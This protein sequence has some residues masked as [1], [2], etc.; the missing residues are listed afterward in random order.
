MFVYS[1]GIRPDIADALQTWRFASKLAIV[2]TCLAC[3][4]WATARLTRPEADQR[5]A[6]AVLALPVAML[7]LAGAWELAMSPP[8]AWP[9]L[10]I[11]R[12]WRLCLTFTVLMSVA[13]LV[14][15]LAALRAGAPR[16]PAVAGAASGLLAGSL[17][18][19]LYAA[20]CTDDS[21]LFVTLWY[22]PAIMLVMLAGAAAGYRVLRW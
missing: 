21:P 7:A 22:V 17:A 8:E 4:L 18:A 12:N 2:L 15:L 14:S 9:A 20:H 13:P 1:L 3:A 16:S 6:L 5:K 11:G 10:A 19:V